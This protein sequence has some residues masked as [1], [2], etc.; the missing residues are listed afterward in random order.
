VTEPFFTIK[1]RTRKILDTG[2]VETDQPLLPYTGKDHSG[3]AMG[4]AVK[5]WMTH[6]HPNWHEDAACRDHPQE[7]FYG[8]ED[9]SH[10]ARHH[11]SLTV[12]E[13]AR[14]RR[15]CNA[16][17][18]QM[19]CLEFSIVNR[20]EFGIWGGSTAGQRK[21]WIKAF[22]AQQNVLYLGDEGDYDEVFGGSFDDDFDDD[23]DEVA[24]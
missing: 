17:P 2:V 13:V 4:S 20:E 6:N 9:R 23:L 19:N 24:G 1:P 22:E 16:C 11:P 7:T 21:K 15:I 18:V 8:D 10:K 3:P 5:F 14:A 12:D